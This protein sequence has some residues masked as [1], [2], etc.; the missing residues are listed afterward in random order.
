MHA[1]QNEVMESHG[2]RLPPAV[3]REVEARAAAKQASRSEWLRQQIEA[4]LGRLPDLHNPH[5]RLHEE[6]AAYVEL[7]DGD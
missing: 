2:L 4:L 6:Q 1:M 7:P 3:W 5:G